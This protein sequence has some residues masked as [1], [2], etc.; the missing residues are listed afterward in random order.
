M[1]LNNTRDTNSNITGNMKNSGKSLHTNNNTQQSILLLQ[2]ELDSASH[3]IDENKIALQEL[4]RQVFDFKK[5]YDMQLSE[6]KRDKRDLDDAL[7][8]N[9]NLIEQLNKSISNLSDIIRDPVNGLIVKL[10][11]T[12]RSTDHALKTL[13]EL[14]SKYKSEI[15]KLYKA[16]RDSDKTMVDF[17]KRLEKLET[18]SEFTKKMGMAM[19][20]SI[21]GFIVKAIWELIAK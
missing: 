13:S 12:V 16:H 19:L 1:A 17:D 21:L 4:N 5:D 9:L 3:H 11:E 20:L 7:N 8:N 2:E 6:Q 15:E 18:S 10:G 14:D